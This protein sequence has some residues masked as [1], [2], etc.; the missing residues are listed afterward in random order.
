MSL[1]KFN[2]ATNNIRGLADKPTQ[3]ALQLKTL[4]DKTGDDLKTYINETLTT[5][6]DTELSNISSDYKSKGDFAVITRTI[7]LR[8]GERTVEVI[9]FPTGFNGN[10]CILI[11][12]MFKSETYFSNYWYPNL[13][14]AGIRFIDVILSGYNTTEGIEVQIR[15]DNPGMFPSGTEMTYKL[16]LMKIS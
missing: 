9:D 7:N 1:T 4:F 6:I 15:S 5:E 16:V 8:S 2:G 3:S 11:G 12:L 14:K 13:I 10:N